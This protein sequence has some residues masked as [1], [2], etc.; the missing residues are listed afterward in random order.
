MFKDK[1]KGLV[2]D[3]LPQDFWPYQKD[4]LKVRKL[5]NDSN[6][7]TKK[8]MVDFQFNRMKELIDYTWKESEGYR[9]H[10]SENNF[11]PSDFKS[12]SDVVKIPFI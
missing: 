10:W 11:N 2:L 1:I 8:Q 6:H 12:L 9:E 3:C 7:F 4:Y 5:I